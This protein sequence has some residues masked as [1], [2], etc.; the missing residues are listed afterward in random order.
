MQPIALLSAV[1]EEPAHLYGELDDAEPIQLAASDGL[2]GLLEGHD[3]VI[4]HSGMGKVAAALAATSLLE[5]VQP[6][7]LIFSGVAG[8]LDPELDI[9][10]VV[11][12][13]NVV[14]FDAGVFN[15]GRLERYQPS[16][17]P[18]INP[19]NEFGYP[20][21]PELL[22]LALKSAE[23]AALVRPR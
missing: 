2:R 21:D 22:E 18:F 11:I 17:L 10:D 7:A 13:D 16:H 19:T 9:G 14:Q 4:S 3:V 6:R 23:A 8:G 20:C 15:N 5:R 12:A 1:P